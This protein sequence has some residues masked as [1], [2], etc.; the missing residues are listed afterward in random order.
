MNPSSCNCPSCTAIRESGI[1]SVLD[2]LKDN[3][4]IDCFLIVK[5]SEDT[6]G[7]IAQDHALFFLYLY[8]YML[9]NETGRDF[10]HQVVY[11]ATTYVL[12]QQGK[13]NE[14]ESPL[15]N[16]LHHFLALDLQEVVE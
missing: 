3:A 12:K 5:N 14:D 8:E 7:S 2:N 6:L 13:Y 10:V 9:K 15:Q 1:Y 11:T 16:F 4:G